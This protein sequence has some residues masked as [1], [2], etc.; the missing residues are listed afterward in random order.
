MKTLLI[1]T[2]TFARIAARLKPFDAVIDV[3]TIDNDC[4]FRR[5]ATGETV[6]PPQPHLGC[7]NYDIWFFPSVAPFLK[8][9]ASSPNLEWFQSGA[10]GLE[11][12]AL[13]M[14]G[15]NAD[16]Y[17]SNHKQSESMAE[18]A[19]W[20]ALD[21]LRKGPAHRALAQSGKW[22]P[23][24]ARE[25]NGSNWLIIGFGS[26]GTSV[27]RRVRALGG[28]V[29][30]LRRTPGNAE[31]ADRIAHP[32]TLMAELPK[33]DVVLLCAPHTP[34]TEDMANAA[35][36]AAMKEDALFL[37]LGRGALVDEAALIAALDAGRPGFAALD[38]TREEP[39]PETSPLWRHPK[40]MVTP[41]D[42]ADT[43]G[44]VTRTDE[45]FLENLERYFEGKTL[46][47][48][49]NPEVFET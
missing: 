34:E 15:K 3:I 18:W 48:L 9:I 27:G 32:D 20:Q 31:G 12:P 16:H 45:T 6:E 4:I 40:I 46:L 1:H 43:P 25:I 36:F 14:I 49:V 44:T 47:H 13:M 30:G 24:T 19:L 41:H 11:H 29:T 7:G 39:L 38:V 26:I 8:A 22:E 37:N 35:F 17:T 33:A 10:A 23:T 21:Y 42:S 2:R 5:A 28:H